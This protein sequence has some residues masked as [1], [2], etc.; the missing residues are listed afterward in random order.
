VNVLVFG[1]SGATGREV[2]TRALDD[3]HTVGAFVRHPEAFRMTHERLSVAVGDVTD[4]ASVQAAVMG[5][6]AVVSTLGAG[7]SLSSHP[8]L[9]A[10]IRNIVMSMQQTSVRR[11]VY[12]SMLGVG[13]SAWQLGFVDRF[14]VLPLVLRN[15]RADHA[16]E[17]AVIRQSPLDWVIVRPPRLTNGPCTGTYRT[18]EGI[19]ENGLLASISRADVADFMVTQLSDDRYSHAAPAILR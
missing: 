10:G 1:A 13:N 7:N 17:E 16:R 8:S 19:R 2:V 11:L 14:L 18:G 12:Q 6:D 5:R 9:T 15:I 3:G 4:M